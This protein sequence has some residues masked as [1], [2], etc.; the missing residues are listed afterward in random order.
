[1]ADFQLFIYLNLRNVLDIFFKPAWIRRVCEKGELVSHY[2]SL[3]FTFLYITLL[4]LFWL[5]NIFLK[6]LTEL[7]GR[8]FLTATLWVRGK[9]GIDAVVANWKIDRVLT[10]FS[11]RERNVWSC[12][13]KQKHGKPLETKFLLKRLPCP[14]D[15]NI[16]TIAEAKVGISGITFGDGTIH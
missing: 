14:D 8:G 15:H 4:F 10:E 2:W 3:F 6:F 16:W 7:Q 5:S 12:R 9:R 11:K 1:M 13:E